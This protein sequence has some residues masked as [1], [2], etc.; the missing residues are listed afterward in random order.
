LKTAHAS[1]K[2]YLSN[3]STAVFFD[4]A[5]RNHNCD[6]LR[7]FPLPFPA[8]SAGDRPVWVAYR[9]FR[10]ERLAI[11]ALGLTEEIPGIPALIG[12]LCNVLKTPVDPPAASILFLPEKSCLPSFC[13]DTDLFLIVL[14]GTRCQMRLGK[15]RIHYLSHRS[16]PFVYIPNGSSIA[17][18]AKQDTIMLKLCVTPLCAGSL[19]INQISHLFASCK[20]AA[21]SMRGL[22]GGIQ[23]RRRALKALNRLRALAKSSKA[24]TSALPDAVP[25][26]PTHPPSTPSSSVSRSARTLYQGSEWHLQGFRQQGAA[27]RG[28]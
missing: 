24:N 20:E 2:R 28:P 16:M 8:P 21:T 9:R 15:H 23:A 3:Y 4:R 25:P 11:D 26:G 12:E 22:H 10:Y 27:L 5:E 6:A 13:V 7:G 17:L 19:A 1:I 14:K 18:K